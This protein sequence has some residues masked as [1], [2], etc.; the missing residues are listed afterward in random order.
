MMMM[1]AMAMRDI[2][3]MMMMMRI[4]VPCGGGVSDDMRG[5]DDI[6]DVAWRRDDS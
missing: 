1:A 5:I 6:D 3:V 2:D 4:N